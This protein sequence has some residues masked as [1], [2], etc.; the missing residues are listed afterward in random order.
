MKFIEN[1]LNSFMFR[2]YPKYPTKILQEYN[3]KCVFNRSL[4][5]SFL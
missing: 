5:C 1:N 3:L 4:Q 2:F